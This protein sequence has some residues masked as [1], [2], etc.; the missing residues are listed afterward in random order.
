MTWPTSWRVYNWSNGLIN[1]A[2]TQFLTQ[3]LM[4]S[5]QGCCPLNNDLFHLPISYMRDTVLPFRILYA[6]GIIYYVNISLFSISPAYLCCNNFT[7]WDLFLL[8]TLCSSKVVLPFVC[9]CV[10]RAYCVYRHTT[11]THL[12]ATDRLLYVK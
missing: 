8:D 7:V 6:P 3:S 10:V 2:H 12:E 9:S 4:F 5:L 1:M 11:G